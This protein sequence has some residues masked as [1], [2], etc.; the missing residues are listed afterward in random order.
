MHNNMVTVDGTKMGKSLGNFITLK[1]LFRTFDPMVIRFFIL[2][3]HYRS[4]LD[5]SDTAI[6]ASQ[7]GL[8]KL[9]ETVRRLLDAAP[10]SGSLD[11]KPFEERTAEAM[12][13]DFNT[14]VAISVIFEFA[15]ALNGALDRPEGLSTEAAAGA[16]AYLETYAGEVLGILKSREELA[17]GEAGNGGETLQSVM[18]V[19][20]ELRTQ[21]RAKKDFA[22]SDTIR[23]LL[24]TKGIELKDTKEGTTWSK[25]RD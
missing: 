17:A 12:D 24:L 19:L 6:R 4:S 18:D 1:E 14:P 10:G 25:K 7:T 13:D 20:L 9:Q 3:S 15:K 8:T 22:M 5:F 23:D 21:A 11:V 16:I 2:Q